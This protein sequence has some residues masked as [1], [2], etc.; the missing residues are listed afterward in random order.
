[1]SV[2]HKM[3]GPFFENLMKGNVPDLSDAGTTIKVALMRDDGAT[4]PTTF[5]FNQDHD[6]WE[7]VMTYECDD[8][9][10]E[11]EGGTGAGIGGQEILLKSVTYADRVTTFDTTSDP[12]KAVFTAEGDITATHAVIYLEEA[13]D[14]A[15]KLISCIDFGGERE[16]VQGE[17]S[18]TW[19]ETGIFK[20]TVAA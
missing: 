11:N 10:Y 8:D 13:T 19:D 17:F 5:T 18:I 6:N 15:S 16:S 20:V 14:A 1:M 2:T 12:K 7:D 9:D 4:S 3:Y